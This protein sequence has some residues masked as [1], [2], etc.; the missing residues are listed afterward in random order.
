MSIIVFHR[1]LISTATV[2][3]AVFAVWE[4]R[5]FYVDGGVAPLAIGVMFILAAT[6]LAYYLINL[7]RFL[8]SKPR[9]PA[10]RS[11]DRKAG[12]EVRG[13]QQGESYSGPEW[14]NDHPAEQ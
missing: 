5:I 8:E 9:R 6:A 4:L 7:Q 14:L 12:P 1:F 13:R 3:C 2:F 11:P 10:G